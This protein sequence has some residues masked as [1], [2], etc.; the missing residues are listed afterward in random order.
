MNNFYQVQKEDYRIS[1]DPSLLQLEVIHQYL[2][3]ESYW[4]QNIPFETVK[5]SIEHSLCFGVYR[6]QEQVGFAR[7][8][9]DQTSFAYLCDVFILPAWQGKGLSKWLIQ[10]MQEHPELQSLRVWMLR[11]KDAHG[12]YEQFG[13]KNLDDD[14]CKRVMQKYNPDVYKQQ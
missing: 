13:W 2:S 4:A 1:T 14:Q 10:S 12:L 5:K 11:T 9:T 6:L 3:K 7:L 8:I